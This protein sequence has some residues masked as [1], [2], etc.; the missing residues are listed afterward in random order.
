M[1]KID[2]INFH[3]HST[4]CD[5]KSTPEENVISAIN[6]GIKILGFSSHSVFPHD[7][8]CNMKTSNFESYCT[9]ILRLKEK[10]SDKIDIRLGFE[11]DYIPDFCTPDFK[12]YEKFN[13]DFLIGSVHYLNCNEGS[14]DLM[15]S[16]DNTPELLLKEIDEKFN[17]DAKALIGYYFSTQRQMLKE[18]CFSIIGHPDLVRKFNDRLNYF[19]EQDEWYKNEL[20]ETA[21]AIKKVGVIS[22]INTG[23]ISRGWLKNPYPSLYFLTLLHEEGVPVMFNSDAHHADNLDCAWEEALELARKAGYKEM[24]WPEGKNLKFYKI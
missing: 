18:G 22:E 13:P 15:G 12:V 23:A 3:T 5:G 19:N 8:E 24:C 20:K 9:E 1:N 21:K 16:V 14:I 10:Y 7:A 17:G 11:A 2:K 4:F 6:K